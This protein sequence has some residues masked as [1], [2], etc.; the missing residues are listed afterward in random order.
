MK[1]HT[2]VRQVTILI[3]LIFRNTDKGQGYHHFID[4]RVSLNEVKIMHVR[5][6]FSFKE[7]I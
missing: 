4:E 6:Y 1:I 7:T 2:E 3:Y 5:S